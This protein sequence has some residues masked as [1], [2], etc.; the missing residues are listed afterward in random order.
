MRAA[1]MTLAAA[2]T[3][4]AGCQEQVAVTPAGL[5][6]VWQGEYNHATIRFKFNDDAE[7]GEDGGDPTFGFDY[8]A[9]DSTGYLFGE[10]GFDAIPYAGEYRLA[11]GAEDEP[12]E[13]LFL[14]PDEEGRMRRQHQMKVLTL[15][16]ES[17]TIQMGEKPSLEFRRWRGRGG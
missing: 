6:G 1:L 12:T 7:G 15:S 8:R 3:L 17:M 10:Y 9:G 4:A 11:G 16:P 14:G 2:A 13:V 5:D